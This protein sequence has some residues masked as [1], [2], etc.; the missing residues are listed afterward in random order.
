M[1]GSDFKIS[2]GRRLERVGIFKNAAHFFDDLLGDLTVHRHEFKTAA[3]DVI[4]EYGI[5]IHE[6]RLLEVDRFEKRV[7]ETFVKTRESNEVRERVEIFQ[8]EAVIVPVGHAGHP[9]RDKAEVDTFRLCE[10]SELVSIVETFVPG[11]VRD[12][13]FISAIP[14]LMDKFDGVFDAFAR[15]DPGRLQNEPFTGCETERGT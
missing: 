12:E 2:P 10:I 4:L 8:R 1:H 5:A 6:D 3:F 7:A 15:H 9:I 14:E 11:V 13:Q